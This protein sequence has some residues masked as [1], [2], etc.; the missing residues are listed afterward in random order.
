MPGFRQ[1]PEVLGDGCEQELIAST[2]HSAQPQASQ[3]QDAFEVREQDLNF[4]SLSTR[5]PVKIGLGNVA[6]HIARR[7]IDAARDLADRCDRTAAR[8]QRAARAIGLPRTVDNGV[9]LGEVGAR[10]GER[11]P[12]SAQRI[13]LW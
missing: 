10:S 1:A 12:L 5:L 7:F 9:G 6:S 4:L 11:A 13:T 8:L 3:V 2:A